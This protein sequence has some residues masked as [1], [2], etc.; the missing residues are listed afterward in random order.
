MALSSKRQAFCDAYIA[1]GM[2]ATQA[3]VEAGYS[4]RTA[5]SQGNRLLKNDEVREYIKSRMDALTEERIVTG[6]E[7]L[8]FL[9]DVMRGEVEETFIGVDKDGCTHSVGYVSQKNQLKAAELLAKCHG[10]TVQ[11]INATGDVSVVFV[12]NLEPDE[13][14]GG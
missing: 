3:A 12:D 14:G 11:N 8:A 7:V 1:N 13:D 5:Y 6:N 2:N 4:E 9:S 10:L